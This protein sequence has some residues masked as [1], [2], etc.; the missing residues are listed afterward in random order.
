MPKKPAPLARHQLLT[1]ALEKDLPNAL[2][3]VRLSVLLKG[4]DFT[5][6]TNPM[7]VPFWDEWQLWA[8]RHEPKKQ[9]RWNRFVVELAADG[10]TS[11]WF[12]LSPQVSID[13]RKGQAVTFAVTGDPV[14]KM[15][16]TQA[17]R[18]L[19]VM[20][21]LCQAIYGLEDWHA[22]ADAADEHGLTRLGGIIRE[23]ISVCDV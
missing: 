8:Q 14:W 9:A 3:T 2:L 23:F 5:G 18:S 13:A 16:F 22:A 17:C 10:I 15:H 6:R 4:L 21:T 19:E 12:D 11:P 7:P 1:I 20:R